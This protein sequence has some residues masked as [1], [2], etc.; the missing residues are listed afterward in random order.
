MNILLYRHIRT[1]VFNKEE[2][3]NRK[4][5]GPRTKIWQLFSVF[6]VKICQLVSSYGSSSIVTWFFIQ[7]HH[8]IKPSYI[9][10]RTETN[11]SSLTG[12]DT[13][14]TRGSLAEGGAVGAGP[15]PVPPPPLPPEIA[16]QPLHQCLSSDLVCDMFQ[17]CLHFIG[18]WVYLMHSKC[19]SVQNIVHFNSLILMYKI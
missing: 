3:K 11:Q 16:E 8:S 14:T 6:V 2:L 19:I 7:V 15:P 12:P 13:R 17:C 10:T 5:S 18:D 4:A 1:I 9:S